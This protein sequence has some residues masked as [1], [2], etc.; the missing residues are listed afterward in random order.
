MSCGLCWLLANAKLIPVQ[1]KEVTIIIVELDPSR[2][3]VQ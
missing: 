3:S 1:L 2:V